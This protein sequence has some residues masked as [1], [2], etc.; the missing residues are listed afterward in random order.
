MNTLEYVTSIFTYPTTGAANLWPQISSMKKGMSKWFLGHP[1]IVV[2]ITTESTTILISAPLLNFCCTEADCRYSERLMPILCAWQPQ[3]LDIIYCWIIYSF[4]L[5]LYIVMLL[6]MHTSTD[7][8]I[9]VWFKYF[10]FLKIYD[11]NWQNGEFHP[12]L[13]WVSLGLFRH[14]SLCRACFTSCVMVYNSCLPQ[15]CIQ[16][17]ILGFNL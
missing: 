8:F 3:H 13:G 2:C 16:Q 10:F 4:L 15:T 12:S 17:A 7:K 9:L 14:S 6:N 11:R 1:F 5:F